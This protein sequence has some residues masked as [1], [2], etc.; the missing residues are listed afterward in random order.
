MVDQRT[1]EPRVGY[2]EAFTYR[3]EIA[4]SFVNE[5]S[6]KSGSAPTLVGG[7]VMK[8]QEVSYGGESDKYIVSFDLGLE[9]G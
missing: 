2:H 1:Y 5:F 7:D 8:T 4:R 6:P 3:E 9:N